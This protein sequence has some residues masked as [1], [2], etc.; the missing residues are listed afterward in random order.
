MSTPKFTKSPL[1]EVVCGVEFNAPEFSSVHFGLYWQTIKDRFPS[2]PLDRPPIGEVEILSILPNLR[3]V[4]FESLDKKQLIQ[5][6][7]NRFHYNW[8]SQ[9]EDDEY[10]HF[11]EIYPKFEQEWQ[12]FQTW[13]QQYNS[14]N[15]PLGK[16]HYELT[17]MNQ[18]DKKFGWDNPRDNYKIFTFVG[19]KW[20]DNL[21]K[22][23][24]F[25]AGIEFDISENV[26]KLIVRLNQIV[27]PK[28]DNNVLLF[29]LT[30]RSVDT[31]LDI[32]EWFDLAHKY[33]VDAFLE[34][35]QEETKKEWGL[36]WLPE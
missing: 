34:L 14:D 36:T 1:T 22:A 24:N 13:W 32:R 30:A 2:P 20:S 7:S 31:K 10:P 29:E 35:I 23:T 33:T 12:H 3:R 15:L 19:K 16:I 28:D 8:R 18:I 27:N 17:Y 25:N 9:N 5:L 21:K 6:Q 4:W 26:G 11:K